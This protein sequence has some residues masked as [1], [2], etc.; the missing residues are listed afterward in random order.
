MVNW[1]QR[2]FL[3]TAML[4]GALLVACFGLGL[5]FVVLRGAAFTSLVLAMAC[6]LFAV[7][8][9]VCG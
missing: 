3:L 4:V 2:R 9:V 6:L 8:L 7:G 5:C 1:H